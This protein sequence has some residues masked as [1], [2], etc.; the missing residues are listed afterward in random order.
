MAGIAAGWWICRRY[1]AAAGTTVEA[2]DAVALWA[3]LGGILGTRALHVIDKWPEIYTHDPLLALQIWRGG[4]AIWGGILGGVAGGMVGAWR[5]SVPIR[6]IIDVG[7]LGLILG[8]AIGRL[9]NIVNGEHTRVASDLPWAFLYTD[10]ATLAARNILGETFAAHPA[11]LYELL[12]DLLILV[13]LI[14]AIG[15]WGGSG[16]V[17]FVYT[18][19]YSLFRF[20]VTFLRRDELYGPFTQAQWIAIIVGLISAVALFLYWTGRIPTRTPT[21]YRARGLPW[22]MPQARSDEGA[23]GPAET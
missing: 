5:N 22:P 3:I 21:W 11:H 10:S 6:P 17:F 13:V 2:V 9:A 1:A 14:A 23:D 16:R 7:G 19:G 18:F 4:G 8:Q 20:L 12:A 15:R